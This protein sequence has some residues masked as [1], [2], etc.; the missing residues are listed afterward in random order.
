MSSCCAIVALQSGSIW[1]YRRVGYW[2]LLLLLSKHVLVCLH[3]LSLMRCTLFTMSTGVIHW[4]A[5]ARRLNVEV[6]ASWRRREWC[7]RLC[8]RAP[9]V[10]YLRI[11]VVGNS[12]LALTSSPHLVSV[13]VLVD[14]VKCFKKP[15]ARI[16]LAP[17]DSSDCS[18]RSG[19]QD[20]R[21]Q[22][23]LLDQILG[24]WRR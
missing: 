1:R 11:D 15:Q 24:Q 12:L 5:H 9:S 8:A 16:V 14:L 2:L 19:L 17:K 10:V 18:E 22:I 6:V 3:E 4:R 23:E 20:W 7:P 21:N 13:R